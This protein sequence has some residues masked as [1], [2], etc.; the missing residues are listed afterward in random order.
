LVVP[1]IRKDFRKVVF[2]HDLSNDEIRP[3]LQAAAAIGTIP[4]IGQGHLWKILHKILVWLHHRRINLGL[5]AN[6]CSQGYVIS[7]F[8]EVPTGVRVLDI[9]GIA[10]TVHSNS[11]CV[12]GNFHEK[13]VVHIALN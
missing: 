5:L 7:F 11:A 13:A 6:G 1:D 12:F 9:G 8:G 10:T 3:N 2:F 4:F